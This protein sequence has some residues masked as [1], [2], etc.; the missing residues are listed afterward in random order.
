MFFGFTNL[1]LIA[2]DSFFNVVVALDHD[3]PEPAGQLARQRL[4]RHQAAAARS[5]PA[6]KATQGNI[7]ATDKALRHHAKQLSRPVAAPAYP[8]FA[9]S[10]IVSAPCQSPP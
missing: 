4:G 1:F 10:P 9:S 5:E 7:F 2:G 3:A 8:F 6:V